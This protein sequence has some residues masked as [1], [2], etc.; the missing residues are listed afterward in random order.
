SLFTLLSDRHSAIDGSPS[1]Q[2]ACL[3]PSRTDRGD[4]GENGA[5]RGAAA[6]L[7]A[8]WALLRS[9]TAPASMLR[10]ACAGDVIEWRRPHEQAAA[11]S[12]ATGRSWA[13]AIRFVAPSLRPIRR[14]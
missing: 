13:G 6:P 11:T 9:E 4:G 14:A 1:A 7:P 2:A 10:I 8:T 12:T 3:G 5:C